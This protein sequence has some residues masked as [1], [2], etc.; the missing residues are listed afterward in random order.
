M[1]RLVPDLDN[2]LTKP[3]TVD[4]FQVRSVSHTRFIRKIGQASET[5]LQA[6]TRALA[7]VLSMQ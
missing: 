3:S 4:T 6:I 7:I 5:H 2:Q 1:V